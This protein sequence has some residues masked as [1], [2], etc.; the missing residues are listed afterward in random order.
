M[1]FLFTII[2]LVGLLAALGY[3]GYLYQFDRVARTRAGGEVVRERVR[4]RM[5]AA[6]GST[7]AAVLGLALTSGSLVADVI[8]IILAGGAGV[9]SAGQIGRANKQL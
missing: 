8:G 1:G 6:L 5:P 2:A 7:A 9:W 4:R 3:T